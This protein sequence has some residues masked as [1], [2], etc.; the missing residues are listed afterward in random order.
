MQLSKMLKHLNAIYPVEEQA[1]SALMSLSKPLIL[2]KKDFLLC[3]GNYAHHIYWLEEGVIRVFFSQDGNEYN[4]TFFVPGMFPTPIT[5]LVS[6]APSQLSFQALTP[7]RLVRFSYRKFRDLF[8]KHRCLESLMLR[9]ME[10]QWI[11]KERHDIRMVMN[12][13]TTN[14]LTFREEYPDLETLIPQ[15]HIASY[16]GITPIQL[17]RIRARLAQKV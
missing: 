1:A 14:Y 10:I 2:V 4:K 11:K 16:L 17:S 7:C 6:D 13:A 8:A 9:I 12:D 3:E 5:A 15:Y